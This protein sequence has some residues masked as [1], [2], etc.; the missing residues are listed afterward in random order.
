MA[1]FEGLFDK[2]L[3]DYE[4]FTDEMLDTYETVSELFDTA[5]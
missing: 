3:D 2:H 4:E 5:L 1:A